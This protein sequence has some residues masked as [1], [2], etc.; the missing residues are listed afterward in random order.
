[1]ASTGLHAFHSVADLEAAI[2]DY[3]E[4]HNVDPKSFIWTAPLRAAADRL[5]SD[6][7][8]EPLDSIDPRSPAPRFRRSRA[9][10]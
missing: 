8:E 5:V 6:Q 2:E 4:Q 9:W 3:L 10:P 7:G 1:M